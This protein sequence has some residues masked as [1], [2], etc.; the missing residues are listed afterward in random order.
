M[1]PATLTVGERLAV[2]G[3]VHGCVHRLRAAIDDVLDSDRKIILVGDYI[4]RGP[5]SRRVLD[6]LAEAQHGLGGRLVLLRGNHEVALLQMLATGLPAAFLRHRG[7]TTIQSYLPD[8]GPNV[9][10]DFR[11]A[12]PSDHLRLLQETVLYAEGPDLLIS[13]AGYHPDR[14]LSRSEQDL[15]SGRWRSL[16]ECPRPPRP[17]VVVGHYLQKSGRPFNSE[18]LIGIDTGCG[19]LPSAPLTLLLLPERTFLAY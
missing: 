6:F 18:H 17:L 19:T 16:T 13:H 14:P 2:V 12:F 9:L 11:R 10:E 8:P 7:A 4:N 15:T 1:T 3:D 5:D